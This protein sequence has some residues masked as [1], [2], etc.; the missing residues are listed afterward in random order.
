MGVLAADRGRGE[1]LSRR[2]VCN[3]W[4]KGLNAYLFTETEANLATVWVVCNCVLGNW[5][6][7]LG[8]GVAAPVL[9]AVG[10]ASGEEVAPQAAGWREEGPSYCGQRVTREGS[11]N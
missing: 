4:P 5:S 2:R 7:L 11:G 9:C 10:V 1:A 6:V 8:C 3:G